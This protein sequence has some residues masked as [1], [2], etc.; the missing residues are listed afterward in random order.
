MSERTLR[1][2]EHIAS[3]RNR[4]LQAFNRLMLRELGRRPLLA[5][6]IAEAGVARST[7][8]DHF[9]G[10]DDLLLEALKG[11]MSVIADAATRPG[12]LDRL[13][14]ILAHFHER[15]KEAADLLS[16]PL[17]TRIARVLAEQIAQ[18]RDGLTSK[19]A[20]QLATILLSLIHL[21]LAG[22]APATTEEAARLLEDTAR[23]QL[24]VLQAPQRSHA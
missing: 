2:T 13:T 22:T 20:L 1:M 3:T 21:W 12:E 16:G 9:E 23:V 11:P 5:D 24:A 14:A 15:R 10:R 7:L 18:R 4:L 8:Y 17:R 19:A 6:V